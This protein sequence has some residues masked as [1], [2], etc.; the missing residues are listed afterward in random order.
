MMKKLSE[1]GKE[2]Q[3]TGKVWSEETNKKGKQ[4]KII[5]HVKIFFLDKMLSCKR[6]K[7]LKIEKRK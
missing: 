6:E 1:L 5:N 7:N 4:M 2:V 3:L